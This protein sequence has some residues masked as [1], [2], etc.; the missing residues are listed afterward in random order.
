MIITHV[1]D[2][3]VF[4]ERVLASSLGRLNVLLRVAGRSLRRPHCLRDPFFMPGELNHSNW[5]KG[6]KD[7]D[8]AARVA[9]IARI[10]SFHSRFEPFD[11]PVTV[12]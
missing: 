3:S 7:R 12:T 5:N 10:N 9:R 1:K 2:L 4:L 8:G 11:R 6:R